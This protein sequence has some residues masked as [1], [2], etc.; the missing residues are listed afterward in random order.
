MT[1]TNLGAGTDPGYSS[2]ETTTLTITNTAPAIAVT[3]SSQVLVGSEYE[4]DFT[5]T[6]PGADR[7]FEWRIDWGDDTPIEIF[8]SGTTSAKHVYEE[9][10]DAEIL[11][12]AVDEDSTPHATWA[13]PRRKAGMH[14]SG[15]EWAWWQG[16]CGQGR[17]GRCLLD[18][19]HAAVI[20]QG[21][22]EVGE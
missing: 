17:D 22:A 19:Q 8:G 20:R 18:P 1:A 3:G 6:D 5:A 21:Q 13:G 16:P 14:R 12:G 2:E 11:V 4:I 9:P 15:R 7:V 10:K